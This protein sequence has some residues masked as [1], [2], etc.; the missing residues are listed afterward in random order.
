M[1]SHLP[2]HKKHSTN[3]IS[4]LRFVDEMTVA[5]FNNEA[6]ILE[7]IDSPFTVKFYGALVTD[8]YYCFVT[9]FIQFGSLSTLIPRIIQGD[10]NGGK[11]IL[12]ALNIA[13][14]L[15]YLHENSILYRDLKPE[16]VLVF[17][18]VVKPT[19]NCVICK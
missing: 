15:K 8:E 19:I 17:S 4:Q 10:P 9:E 18:N 13:K 11:R 1:G 2:L 3:V 6:D 7:K 5:D 12:I 14:A 16:N